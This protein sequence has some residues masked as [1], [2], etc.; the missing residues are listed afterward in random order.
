MPGAVTLWGTLIFS[1]L[2]SVAVLGALARTALSGVIRWCLGYA[3]LA[4]ASCWI[5]IAGAQ[6]RAIT[7][8]GVSFATLDTVLL[9]V[10]GTRCFFGMPPVRRDECLALLVA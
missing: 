10:Q 9:L 5:L 6:G 2:I 8:V 4:G 3:L 7:I 1:C